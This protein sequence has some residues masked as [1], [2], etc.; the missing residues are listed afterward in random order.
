M[1]IEIIAPSGTSSGCTALPHPPIEQLARGEHAR[2]RVALRVVHD[3]DEGRHRLPRVQA[4]QPSNLVDATRN[5][6]LYD[7]V[8]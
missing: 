2:R 6:A 4:G 5:T 7:T 3:I 8:G 1:L